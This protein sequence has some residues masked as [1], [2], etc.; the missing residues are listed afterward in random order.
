MKGNFHRIFENNNVVLLPFIVFARRSCSHC[1]T[2]LILESFP[3]SLYY[4]VNPSRISR[5]L[6]PVELCNQI[7]SSEVSSSILPV[8]Y[9]IAYCHKSELI[10]R[11]ATTGFKGKVILFSCHKHW[12]LIMTRIWAVIL[13]FVFWSWYRWRGT[14]NE[15]N[16]WSD[17]NTFFSA[18]SFEILFQIV[19]HR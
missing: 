8:C 16:E 4:K 11:S 7:Q 2:S 14:F 15:I 10:Y 5:P 17:I 19:E 12:L 6:F 1:E 3:V 13:P 9:S 18:P